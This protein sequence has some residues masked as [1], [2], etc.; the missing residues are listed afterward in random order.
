MMLTVLKSLIQPRL[1]YCSVL[2]SPRDQS[3]INRLERVQKQFVSQ[4]KDDLLKGLNY[5]EK[6]STLQVFSQERRRER[7]IICLLWKLS[8]GL[9][10]GYDVQWSHSD[11]RGRIAVPK[12]VKRTAPSKVR[13]AKEK[14]V[15][16]HG[17]KLFNSLPYNLRNENSGDFA[18]FKNNLDHFLRTIPDQPTV[19]GL[20]RS[21]PSNSLIDQIPLVMME[22]FNH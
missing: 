17:A 10:D 19:V 6:L 5:W 14:T 22:N 21:A 11:R 3:A 15:S 7:F 13:T 4:I 18:L 8:Q 9:V 2:W 12:H 16:V 1:D 20:G